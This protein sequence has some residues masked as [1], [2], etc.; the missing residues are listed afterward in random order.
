MENH[1]KL[2]RVAV[3]IATYKRPRGLHRLLSSLKELKFNKS[4]TPDWQ[5]II[6]DNDASASM[7]N[8]VEDF[9]NSSS[10]P[11]IYGTASTRGIASARNRAIVLAGTVDFIAF[12]DDDEVADPLWLDEL[13]HTQQRFD[14]DVVNGPVIPKFE[15]PA[16]AWVLKGRFYNKRRF[17]TGTAITWA[18]T[19]NILIKHSWLH[20][21]PGPFDENLNLTGGS[22]TLLSFQLWRLGAKM[23]WSDEAIV[24]E[25][26][27]PGRVSVQW[28][29]RR[30]YR[31]GTNTAMIETKINPSFLARSTRAM[32]SLIRILLGFL[33]LVPASIYRGYAGLIQSLVYINLGVGE[34]SGLAGIRFMEYKHIFG[35]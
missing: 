22:D 35:N 25:Y 10:I 5:I 18:S 21:V 16:P 19:A 32:K 2:T 31:L 4:Q 20:M 30:A 24:E 9:K 33:L 7:R 1:L 12:I 17:P 15:E 26:N 6:A 13:L 27:P 23:V 29:L 14:A 34:L 3:C 11:V 8:L 28:I